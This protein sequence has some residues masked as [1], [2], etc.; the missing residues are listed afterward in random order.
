VL[1][2]TAKISPALVISAALT[3]FDDVAKEL[4]TVGRRHLQ[5]PF[6]TVVPLYGIQTDQ[7]TGGFPQKWSSG[8]ALMY[9]QFLFCPSKNS[10]LTVDSIAR[11]DRMHPVLHTSPRGSSRW[12]LTT[13]YALSPEAL[14][15]LMGMLRELFGSTDEPDLQIVRE[16][17]ME[18][19]PPEARAS[20]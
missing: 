18:T 9:K 7:H 5:Q 6:V 20:T 1:V 10:P 19:L 17:A 13:D 4:N 2:Q 8:F 3:I 14:G 15:V 16:L 12:F 11:L